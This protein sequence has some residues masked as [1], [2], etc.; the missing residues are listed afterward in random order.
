[1]RIATA[2]AYQNAIDSM[3][4]RQ[5]K[6]VR[7]QEEL[8]TGKKLLSAGDDPVA[9][10]AA[11][12]TRSAQRRIEL[13]QRMNDFATGQLQVADGVLSSV[14]DVLQ[15]VREGVIQAGNGGYSAADRHQIATQ[16]RGY[17]E[18]LLALANRPDGVGGF[19]FGGQGSKTA[20]FTEGA[21]VTYDAQPG[22]QEV[23]LDATSATVL[24]G[25]HTFMDIPAAT[26]TQSIFDLLDHT[27]AVLDD[28]TST[29]PT[30]SSTVKDAVSGLD[31]AM[32]RVSTKRTEVGEGLRALEARDKLAADGSLQLSSQL[33]KLVD[34][35][36]AKAISEFQNNQTALTAAMRSYAQISKMSLFDYL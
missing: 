19:L 28:A 29:G 5:A 14:G 30:V 3:T 26:G 22:E 33:S 10:A 35:D 25:R 8:S 7:N 27:I 20:P 6:L 16:L 36:Y 4:E 12:R 34:V 1:V 9:A 21:S 13:Q 17:R 11:E 31:F 24:D 23:G 18:E 32:D 2:Y 15:L